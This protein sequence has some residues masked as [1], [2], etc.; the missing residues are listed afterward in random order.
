MQAPL[1]HISENKTQVFLRIFDLFQNVGALLHPASQKC[2]C[3]DGG[4]GDVDC[5]EL[6]L[7]K[8]CGCTL[9]MYVAGCSE[10]RGTR[11]SQS[12]FFLFLV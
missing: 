11:C 9:S 3:K 5:F 6:S 2:V 7:G 1:T 10:Q 12:I 4:S 8:E